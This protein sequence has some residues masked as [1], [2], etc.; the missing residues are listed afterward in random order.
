MSES[1]ASVTLIGTTAY[2]KLISCISWGEIIACLKMLARFVLC[3]R[4]AEIFYW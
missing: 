3:K 1:I 2:H 4:S